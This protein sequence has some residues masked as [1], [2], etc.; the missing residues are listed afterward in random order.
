MERVA[1]LDAGAQYG[2]VI[3]RR[4]RE[5][6]VCSDLLPINTPLDKLLES[7]Y[8]GVIIS[9]SPD[10]VG[11]HGAASCDP[12]IFES[13]IPILGICYGMQ[14]MNKAFGGHVAKGESREDGQFFIDCDTSS[15]LF[16]GLSKCEKVLLTHGDQCI[17]SG[18][19][20]NIIAKSGSV[21]SAI[22]NDEKKMYGVQF[23][24]EVD[25]TPCGQ[26]ILKNFLLGICELK[27]DYQMKDRIEECMENIRKRVGQ[28]KVLVLLSGGVDSTVCAA[29][30]ARTIHP[31]QIIAVHIDN[32]FM[33]KNESITVVESL[34]ALGIQVHLV[35]AR[36]RFQSGMT[37]FQVQVKTE[38]V[39]P[40]TIL[41]SKG[42]SDSGASPS[43][44]DVGEQKT[45]PSEDISDGKP[46]TVTTVSQPDSV[47][48]AGVRRQ[49]HL[50]GGGLTTF[51]EVRNIPIGPLSSSTTNPEEKRRIIGDMFVRVAQETWS[52]LKLDPEELLLC[53]GTLR[54]DLIESA[55]HQVSLRAD[56]I[57]TH[58]NTTALVQHLQKEGLVIEPLADFHK[59]EVRQI[60]RQLGLP[61]E[62]VN[63]HPFPGPGLAIRILCATEPYMERDFSETTSLIKMI[64]GYHHMSQK[65]HA[66]LTR[67]NTA[68][69]P[70]EQQRLAEITM[71]RSI[72]A[73]LLPIRTVGVQGDRRTYS[74]ACA[75]SSSSSPD[76]DALSFLAHLIPR[77]CHNINRVVYVFGPQVTHPVND[78]T[79][80]YLREPVIETLR[81]VDDRVTTVLRCTRALDKVSQLPVVLLPIHFDRDLSQVVALPSVLRS[82]V[83][84]PIITSD[85][86][87]GLAAIPGV[88]IPE[89]IV[90]QMC[91]AAQGVPGISRVLYDLTCKPPA[92]IEWE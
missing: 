44:P 77:V 15:P 7:G 75:L 10:S 58:H 83:L 34:K 50:G 85:F 11:C 76:W 82:V 51:M 20:F 87:T 66:L 68:A 1:I 45:T 61:E 69:R 80:T 16:K 18:T 21:L 24:P 53:Q 28:N 79:V 72:A 70:E 40:A 56:A 38:S 30:L 42:H 60:G 22:G 37:T 32:G 14:L 86:M 5:L 67:I 35:N 29:L 48:S 88:H 90:L 43:G 8:K 41:P 55:S 6:S 81:E 78:I 74:Y 47:L 59:D 4:V 52:E 26:R 65:P 31:S 36:L 63:R 3:D 91:K 73:H 71:Q 25:L 39:A 23:H 13:G 84:R 62:I 57:K 2:K 9:G 92:T 12:K 33:R 17:T 49:P 64:A 89:E 54:P 27:G 46:K 19:G